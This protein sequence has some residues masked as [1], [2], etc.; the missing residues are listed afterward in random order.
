MLDL[1]RGK[2]IPGSDYAFSSFWP[3]F[4]LQESQGILLYFDILKRVGK[5]VTFASA[6]TINASMG[7]VPVNIYPIVWG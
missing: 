3:E 7:A 4:P 5:A 2:S 6:V 1:G